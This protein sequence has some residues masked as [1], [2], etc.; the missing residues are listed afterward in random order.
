MQ[1]NMVSILSAITRPTLLLD[2]ERARRNIARMADKARVSGVRFRPHFKTHQ[3]L[4]VGR[5]F[6]ECGVSEITVSSVAMAEYFAA[7]GWADI[8]VAFPANW[9]EIDSINALAGKIRLGLILESVETVRFLAERLLSP[10]DLWIDVDAGYHRTG[11]A[12]DATS[13]AV[14]LARA[15]TASPLLRLRGML[16]HAGHTYATNAVAEIERVYN[17]TAN[18]MSALR[19]ELEAQVSSPLLLSIGDTPSC[20]V[21]S[22]LSAVDEI[23]PGN[24]V[25]YD[26]MQ[27]EIGSC[28]L[29]DIAVALACP[30]VAK[31]VERCQVT[32]H[33]GGVHLS[34]EFI[35]DRQG[36]KTYG[37]VALPSD[38][39]A[40][41]GWGQ[42]I[43]TAHVSSISQ[44][45]GVINVDRET[46]ERIPLGG[47]LMVL[48]V[49]SCMTADVMGSYTTLSG[50][51]IGMMPRPGYSRRQV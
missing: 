33:G 39:A 16:T 2:E 7:G 27:A 34:K 32:V 14:V 51:W 10:V 1:V 15:I 24:F 47:L 6:A 45:H 23:R 40:G 9:R 8:T 31:N 36:R 13:E 21:V 11:L 19:A 4:E 25:F 37:A 48:P 38:G 20:S 46:F 26:F 3:S 17:E 18:R 30:V 12:W 43:E 49:H 50:S 29:E 35:I 41:D 42:V 22:D 28:S 5:W 44:E